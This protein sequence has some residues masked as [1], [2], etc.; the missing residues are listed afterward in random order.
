[1]HARLLLLAA[2]AALAGSPAL[3]QEVLDSPSGQVRITGETLKKKVVVGDTVL[4]IDDSYAY[5]S[6]GEKVGNLIL[7]HV[8]SGGTGCPGMFQWLDTTP[9][10]VGLTKEFG[11]CSDLPVVSHTDE[12]V[13]VTL[14][15]LDVS[16]GSIAFDYDGKQITE[17]MLGLESSGVEPGN[18]KAWEGKYAVEFLGAP[19]NE[20]ALI[21]LMGWEMLDLARNSIVVTSEVLEP[22]GEWLVAGGC[23]PHNCG[24][25]FGAIALHAETGQVLV[26][27]KPDGKPAQLFGKPSGPL[28]VRIRE[29]MTAM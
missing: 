11:T 5:A 14:P 10:Q 18:P 1:M 8:S 13:T 20:A 25:A 3:A 15:S 26:A 16:K 17:R 21:E 9:G 24:E 23:M 27:I 29:V 22:Q 28:P 7:I 4:P 19:E 2:T 6:L 12:V